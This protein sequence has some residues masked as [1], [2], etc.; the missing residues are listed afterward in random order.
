M[1]GFDKWIILGADI[2]NPDNP[3]RPLVKIAYGEMA[4]KNCNQESTLTLYKDIFDGIR[5]GVYDAVFSF[6]SNGKFEF[7]VYLNGTE[8]A[9]RN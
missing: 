8:I 4:E 5:N 2:K 9:Y 7:H 3:K 6:H 1:N